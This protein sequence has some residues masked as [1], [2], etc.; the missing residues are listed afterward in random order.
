MV[1]RN[2]E[3]T[4]WLS[5]VEIYNEKVY[6]LLDSV[7]DESSDQKPVPRTAADPKLLLTRKALPLRSSPASDNIDAEVEGKYI[8]GLKQFRVT[9]A[10]QAKSMVKL[11]QLHRRVFGTLANHQSSRSHGMVIIK[12]MRGHRG[13]RDVSGV[14]SFLVQ[15]PTFSARIRPLSKCHDLPSWI[16]PARSAQNIRTPLATD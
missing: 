4:V 13:E 10:A 9:S 16:S 2:Y 14:R 11:G 7:K 15:Q 1:D 5:Y 12:I 8:S 6:D 3:Y